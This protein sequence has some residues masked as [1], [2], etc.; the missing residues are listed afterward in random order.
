MFQDILRESW[1]YQ[2]IGQE[3]LEKGF[4]KGREEERQREVQR[5]SQTLM[6]LVQR[7]FPEVADLA[8]QRTVEIEDPEA[9]QTVILKLLAA[10]TVDEAKQ[11]LLDVGKDEKKH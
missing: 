11:I 8:R 3:F 5:Q 10:Q 1:V 2:E 6:S 7:H 9:L 4:E